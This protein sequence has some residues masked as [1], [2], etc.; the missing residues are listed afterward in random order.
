MEG[1]EE[2]EEEEEDDDACCDAFLI[3]IPPSGD[4]EEEEEETESEQ[5]QQ[6][7]RCPS[8]EAGEIRDLFVRR[9]HFCRGMARQQRVTARRCRNNEDTPEVYL[10]G[11]VI[12]LYRCH[13]ICPHINECCLQLFTL[14][15]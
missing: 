12:P 2:E 14:I 10:S 11:Y 8:A 6:Q 7:E 13:N 15:V 9:L 1:E 4:Y 5:Q 3:E